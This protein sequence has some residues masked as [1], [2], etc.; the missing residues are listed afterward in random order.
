MHLQQ[1]AYS[2]QH[3]GSSQKFI[4]FSSKANNYNMQY[5]VF[6]NMDAF[7]F[8]KIK[9][10][11]GINNYGHYQKVCTM[12]WNIQGNFPGTFLMV[13]SSFKTDVKQAKDR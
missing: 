3:C 8:F 6:N 7:D 2:N 10:W 9:K 13:Y 1:R 4:I 12:F 5:M 11:N